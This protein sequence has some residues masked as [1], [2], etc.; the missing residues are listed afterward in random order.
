MTSRGDREQQQG[1]AHMLDTLGSN[2]GSGEMGRGREDEGLVEHEGVVQQE[3]EAWDAQASL[4]MEQLE[5][6]EMEQMEGLAPFAPGVEM[7][8]MEMEG[9]A[10]AADLAADS[11]RVAAVDC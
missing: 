9:L 10:T 3:G 6:L 4:E 11:P 7:Q 1:D 8:Q 2:E 5:G